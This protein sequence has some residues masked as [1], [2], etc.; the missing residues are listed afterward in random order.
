M[1]QGSGAIN[2]QKLILRRPMIGSRRRFKEGSKKC[3][4]KISK[5]EFKCPG[6]DHIC[7]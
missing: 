7:V 4:G 6:L 1:G 3:W 5:V 2:M